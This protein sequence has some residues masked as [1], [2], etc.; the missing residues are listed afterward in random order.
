MFKSSFI[1]MIINML[2]R[3]LG[4]VREMII[5]SVFGA[6]GMTDAYFSATKIPNFFTTLFGEGSLGTVFI[7]IYNRGIEEQGKERTD[8]FVFS[9]LNL[10]VAFTST[11]SILMILFSRQI[12][13]ITT[14]FADPERFETANMLLKI[15][16]FY[17]LFIALS[18]VVSSLLN[19][20][21]K[22]AVAASMGIVF[23]LTILL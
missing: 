23:N 6:T 8:E 2:S 15:V 1:V 9:V 14:G 17:F 12:L 5:G 7:P 10:I 18:G 21:K 16:A 3:I 4:L 20:Y 13:K 19:N 11:M 22:F